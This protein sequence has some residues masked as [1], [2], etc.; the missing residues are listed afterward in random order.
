[1]PTTISGVAHAGQFYAGWAALMSRGA[2]Q[3][4]VH[5]T[6]SGTVHAVAIDKRKVVVHG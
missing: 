4:M 2:E 5:Y 6:G 3:D 1:M